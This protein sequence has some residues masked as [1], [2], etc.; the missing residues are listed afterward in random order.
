MVLAV[1]LY[2]HARR[3]KAAWASM[4]PVVQYHLRRLPILGSGMTLFELRHGWAA[5][6]P[7]SRALAPWADAPASMSSEAWTREL[8]ASWHRLHGRFKGFLLSY[9]EELVRR[10]DL[11]ARARAV[12]L[13]LVLLQRPPRGEPGVS[14]GLADNFVGPFRIAR[15]I[16]DYQ[17]ELEQHGE[18]PA[19]TAEAAVVA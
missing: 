16:N 8:I 9:E 12:D 19:I 10:R 5:A 18:G 11:D 17:V 1:I 13:H 6:E 7:S 15:R 3:E 2:D 14:R 4:L